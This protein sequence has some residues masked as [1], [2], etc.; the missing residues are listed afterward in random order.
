MRTLFLDARAIQKYFLPEEGN[1]LMHWLCSKKAVLC[2]VR[3]ISSPKSRQEFFRAIDEKLLSGRISQDQADRIK[4][5]ASDLFE[6][7]IGSNGKLPL[8]DMPAENISADELARRHKPTIDKYHWD[9]DRIETIVS[10]LRYL[11]GAPGLQVVTPDAGFGE[12]LELEGYDIINPEAKKIGELL[13]E[14]VA[15]KKTE[16]H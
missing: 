2:G 7:L 16:T 10:D 11:S 14:W 13:E 15:E 12:V 1:E 6:G 5:A 9:R 8:P 3:C 4:N